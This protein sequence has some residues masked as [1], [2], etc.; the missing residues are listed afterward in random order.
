VFGFRRRKNGTLRLGCL[1]RRQ[2]LR[3]AS[4]GISDL[5][6][7]GRFAPPTSLPVNFAILGVAEQKG[8]AAEIEQDAR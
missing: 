8:N 4:S 6:E 1:P 5:A 2:G 7:N 3:G